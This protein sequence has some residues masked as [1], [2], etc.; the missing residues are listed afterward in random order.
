MRSSGYPRRSQCEE[1]GIGDRR[2]G[3][4]QC[5]AYIRDTLC[6]SR[7]FERKLLSREVTERKTFLSRKVDQICA[8]EERCGKSFGSS[9]LTAWGRSGRWN[10]GSVIGVKGERSQ[11]A[12]GGL[13]GWVKAG[14]HS[15]LPS[16][17]RM[18]R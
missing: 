6:R 4:G 14:T 13:G 18:G 7:L 1:V 5:G 15:A 9:S 10:D 8:L 17:G 16:E 11:E 2:R 12:T 3:T